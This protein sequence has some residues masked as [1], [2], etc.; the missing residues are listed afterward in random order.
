MRPR[1]TLVS[2]VI[3]MMSSACVMAAEQ[4]PTASPH[5]AHSVVPAA[6]L[7]PV[8]AEPM[9]TAR[10]S[11]SGVHAAT[12]A[13]EASVHLASVASANHRS[14]VNSARGI[15]ALRNR[16]TTMQPL[17]RPARSAQ[18]YAVVERSPK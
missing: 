3:V 4:A 12:A 1:L 6:V 10:E 15:G 9:R 7:Q 17:E 16:E 5:A 13:P 14:H 2:L 18:L 11:P 8:E